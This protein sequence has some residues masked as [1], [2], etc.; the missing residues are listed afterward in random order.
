[1][2]IQSYPALVLNA[3]FEPLCLYPVT[4]WPTDKVF[5]SVASGK[6]IVVE[7][8]DAELRSAH[9]SWQPPSV[10]ALKNYVQPKQR[11]PFS[12]INILVRDKFSCQYCGT[13]LTLDDLTFDHVIPRSK[14]GQTNFANIVSACVSCNARKANKSHMKPMIEPFVPTPREMASLRP[15]RRDNIHDTMVPYLEWAGALLPENDQRSEVQ[16]ATDEGYWEL[17]LEN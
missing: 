14:G 15:L 13:K 1:M 4:M 9:A 2:S 8:Y 5:R 11:V 12:R 16:K 17:P 3:S 6:S 10:I 7:T